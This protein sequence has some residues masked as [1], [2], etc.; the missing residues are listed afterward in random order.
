MK[1]LFLNIF[2]VFIWCNICLAEKIS[3]YDIKIGDKITDHLTFV[4]ID[5]NYMD[6]KENITNSKG[7]RVYGKELIYSYVSIAFDQ[8]IFMEDFSQA[9]IQIYFQNKTDKIVSIAK[10]EMTNNLANCI[11]ERNKDASNYGKKNR[12]SSLF[13]KTEDTHEFPDGMIDYYIAYEGKDRDFSFRC[14]EYTDGSVTKRFQSYLHN[15]NDYVFKKFN[16]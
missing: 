6:K 10:V 1:K 12:I 15:F 14:Y 11:A 7:E 8:E 4:Q 2:L 16:D 5:Q 9:G 13:S 3:F